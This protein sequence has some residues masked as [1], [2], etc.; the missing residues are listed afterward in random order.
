MLVNDTR[1]FGVNFQ[2]I[3]MGY[4]CMWTLFFF[5]SGCVI[6][7]LYEYMNNFHDLRRCVKNENEFLQKEINRLQREIHR[8][9]VE[10]NCSQNRQRRDFEKKASIFQ[11]RIENTVIKMDKL[12]ERVTIVEIV[13]TNQ[14]NAHLLRKLTFEQWLVNQLKFRMSDMIINISTNHQH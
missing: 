3:I 8:L 12:V 4:I 14:G 1:F 11:D 10:I 5:L 2:T 7:Q 13:E 9:Q 6:F